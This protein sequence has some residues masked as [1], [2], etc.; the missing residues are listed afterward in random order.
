MHHDQQLCPSGRRGSQDVEI[1]EVPV[2]AERSSIQFEAILDGRWAA[3]R[4]GRLGAKVRV[5]ITVDLVRVLSL[6]LYKPK[7]KG[8]QLSANPV[9]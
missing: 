8:T 7:Y 4:D 5:G 1:D 6:D 2:L 3:M 9:W